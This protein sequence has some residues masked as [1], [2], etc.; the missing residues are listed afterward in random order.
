L[1]LPDFKP[2]PLLEKIPKT[3]PSTSA[4][5]FILML[6]SHHILILQNCRFPIRF[7][8]Q[9]SISYYIPPLFSVGAKFRL[10]LSDNAQRTI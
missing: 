6:S 4:L 2:K 10:Y 8:T 7:P 5:R 3:F 1:R 9:L